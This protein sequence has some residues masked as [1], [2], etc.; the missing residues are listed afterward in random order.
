MA[1]KK[2]EKPQVK[3]Y[4]LKF[5]F[6]LRRLLIW[7]LILFLFLPEAIFLLT[8]N[9]GIV[10]EIPLT[11]A[12]S[13]IKTGNVEKVEIRGDE[14]ALIYPEENGVPKIKLT[15]KEEGSSFV[16]T[17]QRAEVDPGKVKVEVASQ[18]FSRIFGGVVSL[19]LPKRLI[20]W[21]ELSR[22]FCLRR[23]SW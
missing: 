10:E 15:R 6:S 9:A 4:E 3:K 5:N 22:P 1:E 21:G 8:K 19:V 14:I 18:T 2:E 16:E 20:S 23:V 11:S 7:V 17:L 12:I 13:E